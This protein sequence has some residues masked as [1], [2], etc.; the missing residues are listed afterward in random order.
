MWSGLEASARWRARG[1]PY[2]NGIRVGLEILEPGA[3]ARRSLTLARPFGVVGRS[4]ESDI[5][6][7]DRAVSSRHA[8]L[9]ADA[10]GLFV[11][12]LATRT[13]TRFE[14][15]AASSGWLFPGES[16]EIAGRS[17]RVA[18]IEQDGRTVI[19][20]AVAESPLADSRDA[21]LCELSLEPPGRRGAS[22]AIGSELIFVGRDDSCGIRLNQANVART[23][24]ALLR[25]AASA[26]V[27]CLPGLPTLVNGETARHAR[28]LDDGDLISIGQARFVARISNAEA[29]TRGREIVPIPAIDHARLAT[30]PTPVDLSGIDVRSTPLELVP[31]EAREAVLGWMLG[32]LHAGQSEILRRQD[33]LQ[34]SVALI[35]QHLQGDTSRRLDSQADRIEA[36]A[37]ELARLAARPAQA[38]TSPHLILP[39]L[40]P[41]EPRRPARDLPPAPEVDPARSLETAAWLLDRID[42]VGNENKF[43]FRSLLARRSPRKSEGPEAP[44]GDDPSKQSPDPNP[45]RTAGSEGT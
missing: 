32:T 40:P 34:Q 3:A 14:G 37:G 18:S 5:R 8:Y 17:I 45:G 11:V 30:L 44:P 31:P 21:S 23:H 27:I 25:T 41:G 20:P 2:W 4:A 13:G 6:L 19:P 26:Y 24:C 12:D 36:L 29:P 9:H 38:S 10:R 15:L 39:H 43:S 7:D 33:E 42:R 22:W 16:I 35:L 28:P 1:E